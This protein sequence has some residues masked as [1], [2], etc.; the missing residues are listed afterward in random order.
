MVSCFSRWLLSKNSTDGEVRGKGIQERK[1][2]V[3]S[4]S[5]GVLVGL[6]CS[7]L[8]SYESALKP[9]LRPKQL[10][11]FRNVWWFGR[12]EQC[13]LSETFLNKE[14]IFLVK[15]SY[16]I[17]LTIFFKQVLSVKKE[18]KRHSL[19]ILLFHKNLSYSFHSHKMELLG[20]M[21][22]NCSQFF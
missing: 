7:W 10:N 19:K 18:R 16:Y 3:T 4:D 21:G 15:E 22:K 17:E 14:N 8:F 13:G 9:G 11:L 2:Q 12:T 5:T 20:E 6:I 1:R